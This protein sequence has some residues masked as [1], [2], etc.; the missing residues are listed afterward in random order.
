MDFNDFSQAVSKKIN[1][2]LRGYKE[3]QLKRRIEH[4]MKSQGFD[5]YEAFYKALSKDQKQQDIF[6]DKLTINVSEFFRNEN[7]FEV[8]EKKVLPTLL[9]RKKK[10]RI[11]SA[12]CSNGAEPY[13]VAIILSKI[14]PDV[15]HTVDATDIDEKMLSA[16]RVGSYRNELVKNIS[17]ER[18]EKY[19]Q[20]DEEHWN[21]IPELKRKV[22][23]FKHDLLKDKYSSE[24]DLI[25]CRNVTIYFT[26]ETQNRLYRN[27]W[28]ALAKDGILFIGATESMLNYRE[29]GFRKFSPWFYQK[30]D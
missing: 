4:L 12:A 1:I 8:L 11:W 6:L 21:L 3:R 26:R 29:L 24:Y 14:T 2:D 15:F 7:V 18:L 23:F 16:A 13:S 22:N 5:T 28:K 19:F 25:I 10:L 9:L 20:R 17:Q 30:D 27:F